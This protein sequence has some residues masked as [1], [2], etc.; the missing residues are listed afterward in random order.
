MNVL[1]AR[2]L[3]L[4]ALTLVAVA[5]PL[6][7][8]SPTT[9]IDDVELKA[10][11]ALKFL[12]YTQWPDDSPTAAQPP[13]RS[14]L[15]IGDHAQQRALVVIAREAEQL[16]QPRVEVRW[17][18]PGSIRDAEMLELARTSNAVFI[19]S[20]DPD[21]AAYL[22]QALSSTPVLTIGDSPEF[23]AAG[24]MLGL[25]QM[26][27]RLAFDANNHSIRA[28]GLRVSANVL[29]LARTVRGLE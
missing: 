25:V 17:A 18:N 16:G 19:S 10:A 8:E 15:A 7:A 24:G 11:Y 27:R 20:V 2:L 29:R 26:D 28:A 3:L 4:L 23:M 14:I 22:L 12:H 1:H 5:M 21:D 6:P 13:Q 9:S